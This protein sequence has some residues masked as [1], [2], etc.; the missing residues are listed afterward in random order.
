MGGY[1]NPLME[2]ITRT[3][4][5]L[6]GSV[7]LNAS[8]PMRDRR[9]RQFV[10]DRTLAGFSHASAR[11]CDIGGTGQISVNMDRKRRIAETRDV[12]PYWLSKGALASVSELPERWADLIIMC[13]V[14]EDQ[15]SAE[16]DAL[17][18]SAMR[19]LRPAGWL[20]VCCP[21]LSPRLRSFFAIA[22]RRFIGSQYFRTADDT[23][24]LI[25][26]AGFRIAEVSDYANGFGRSYVIF[27]QR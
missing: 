16:V 27:A 21:K 5:F 22:G 23:S 25:D 15:D 2:L 19:V 20:T 17:L 9:F 7:L 11:I 13:R 8:S 24:A 4:L 3:K 18:H 26:Q 1:K 6:E 14:L 10:C 12:N